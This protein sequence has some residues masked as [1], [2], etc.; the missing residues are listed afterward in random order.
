MNF[1]FKRFKDKT[2]PTLK[3]IVHPMKISIKVQSTTFE[4]RGVQGPA[5]PDPPARNRP[6]RR[7][8]GGSESTYGRSRIGKKT[9]RIFR[10]GF[11]FQNISP[12]KPEPTEL[13]I[14]KKKSRLDISLSDLCSRSLEQNSPC[15]AQPETQSSHLPNMN[16]SRSSQNKI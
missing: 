8:T 2:K 5:S 9:T 12:G 11:G 13:F 14:I 7:S 15:L 6:D 4:Y 1:R 3:S 16:I 10:F